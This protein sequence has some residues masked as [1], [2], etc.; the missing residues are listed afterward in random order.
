MFLVGEINILVSK[1]VKRTEIIVGVLL[2]F[3]TA[4]VVNLL[5]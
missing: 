3:T 1:A 4:I 2:M 5:S